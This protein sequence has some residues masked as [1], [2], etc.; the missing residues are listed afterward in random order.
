MKPSRRTISRDSIYK[1]LDYNDPEK[2]VSTLYGRFM[3]IVI[4]LSMIPLC[5]KEDGLILEIIQWISIVVFIA[6]YAIRFATADKKLGEGAWSFAKYPFTP[7][8]IIDLLSILP[9]F[10]LMNPAFRLARLFRLVS[11]IRVLKLLRYSKSFRVISNV[12]K[13]QREPLL[14]VMAMALAY[15][16]VSALVVFNVE[17]DTFDSIYDAIYWAVI[18]L[19]TVGYGDV[20]PVSEAGRAVSMISSL[21]GIAV[22]AL[23]SAILTA[24]YMAEVKQDG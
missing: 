5:F 14:T 10:T 23:P 9:A 6:D 22:V 2:R 7:M 12:F 1:I 3:A 16:F 20:Y 18:S 19:T 21:V 4:V 11:A 8:A 15:V 13:K 24:G 17:P